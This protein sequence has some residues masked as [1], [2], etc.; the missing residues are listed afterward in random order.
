MQNEPKFKTSQELLER[1]LTLS[2]KQCLEEFL[3]IQA[4]ALRLRKDETTIR[5]WVNERIIPYTRVGG[6]IYVWLP[7]TIEALKARIND[8]D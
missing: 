3:T 8:Y 1:F 6:T 7:G 2:R 4:M 5:R